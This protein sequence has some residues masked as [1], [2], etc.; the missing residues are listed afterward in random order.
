MKDVE[1]IHPV[2]AGLLVQGRP[3]YLPSAPAAAF[4]ILDRYLE[5]SGHDP[6]KVYAHSKVVVVGRSDVVG[7]PAM[8]LALARDATVIS[9]DLHSYRAGL[10]FEHTGAADILVV[11]AGVPGL[12]T[13]DHVKEGAI[14]IDI[15]INPVQDAA[16]HP[17][18]V[19]DVA[20]PSEPRPKQ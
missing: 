17:R 18:L 19:G 11:A 9:C 8:L 2:N 7:R 14:V 3:R 10:L 13:A 20:R 1:A 16:G 15:G 12:I 5:E 4:H 6:A